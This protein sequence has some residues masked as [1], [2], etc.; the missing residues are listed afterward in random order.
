MPATLTKT[1]I[2]FESAYLYKERD[3][4]TGNVAL[5][6]N[7]GYTVTTVEGET[8]RRDLNGY[9]FTGGDKT[10]IV[11]AFAALKAAIKTQEGI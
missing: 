6:A 1:D 4:D 2:E 10:R 7:V 9:E 11:N 5:K 8:I 3:P